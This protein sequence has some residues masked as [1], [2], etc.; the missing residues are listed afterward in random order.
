MR[1]V[2]DVAKAHRSALIDHP[3]HGDSG[4][5][6]SQPRNDGEAL[7]LVIPG[8]ATP[9]PGISECAAGFERNDRVKEIPGSAIRS[10]GMTG[11]K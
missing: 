7:P 6:Y 9:E 1:R 11:K 5:C 2:P 3:H 4:F 8:P 10:P